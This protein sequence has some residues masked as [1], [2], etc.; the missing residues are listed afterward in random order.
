M[1]KFKIKDSL[2]SVLGE[3]LKIYFTNFLK[4][5]QYMLFPVFGQVIGVALIFGLTGWFTFALPYL[6]EQYAFLN[7]F[8]TITFVLLLLT[9]PGF[10][11]FL[12]AF[13]DYLV[14]YG[15]LNSMTEAVITTGKLYDFKAHNQVVTSRT[16]TFI[17]L[18]LIIS[19]LSLIAINP[20][21]WVLGLIFFIYFILVFQVFAF[22]PDAT[23]TS[24]FKHSFNLVKGNF[25][26]TFFIMFVLALISHYLINLG[27]IALLDAVKLGEFF[28]GIFE[29]WASTLPLTDINGT[30]EYFK[31]QTITPLMIANE[32]WASAVLFVVAGLTLPMRSICWTLWYKNLSENKSEK[33]TKGK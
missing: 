25:G 3:G 21:F 24:C 1:A 11:I 7:N 6:T 14:A 22:E 31:M 23:V 8:T 30:L 9:L 16:G 18:L 28:K 19:V 12:K 4:F 2:W 20:L 29:N 15:A 33:K 5:T 17:F 27:A 26:R 13:W 10:A 32:I